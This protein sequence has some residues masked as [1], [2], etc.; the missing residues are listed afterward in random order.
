MIYASIVISTELQFLNNMHAA[1]LDPSPEPT[2]AINSVG[3]ANTSYMIDETMRTAN[4]YRNAYPGTFLIISK[5]TLQRAQVADTKEE[6]RALIN[7]NV[8]LE[9]QQLLSAALSP[10]NMTVIFKHIPTG[11]Y[12]AITTSEKYYQ[13][14]L[15]CMMLANNTDADFVR[16]AADAIAKN[17][18]LTPTASELQKITRREKL[19]LID[20]AVETTLKLLN[21]IDYQRTIDSLRTRIS[22]LES[23]LIAA[24]AKMM[25]TT[26]R[27]FYAA[28]NLDKD[29]AMIEELKDY[30]LNTDG[31]EKIVGSTTQT[32]IVAKAYLRIPE[33]DKDFFKDK[34]IE[35][36]NHLLHAKPNLTALFKD[37]FNNRVRFP[38]YATYTL[39]TVDSSTNGG[40]AITGS[41]GNIPNSLYDYT[42]PYK[43]FF[44]KHINGF[45]CFAGYKNMIHDMYT[46][47]DLVG[48]FETMI[49]CTASISVFD[50]TVMREHVSMFAKIP[51]TYT[52]Q[53]YED[54]QWNNITLEEYYEKV[55][56]RT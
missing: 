6:L 27:A 30:L 51:S 41:T 21:P 36:P 56:A 3:S 2:V 16:R 22:E 8:D 26:A 52:L 43:K 38:V 50:T 53:Y 33:E 55:K 11:I 49:Q 46:K 9:Y 20:K 10:R 40:M 54:N 34:A 24:R 7:E 18:V 42:D 48:M 4:D 5:V 37:I 29:E 19:K 17:T 35:S 15:G 28:T 14:Y 47:R 13:I 39:Q 23:A 45:N 25:D 32:F 1:M 31:I 12:H 44:N